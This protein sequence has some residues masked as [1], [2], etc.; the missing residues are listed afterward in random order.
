[1]VADARAS[2]SVKDSVAAPVLR[3]LPPGPDRGAIKLRLSLLPVLLVAS[4]IML[5]TVLAIAATY[6]QHAQ[7]E[8]ARIETI[9][10]LTAARIASWVENIDHESRFLSGS[11]LFADL[12]HRF[13]DAGDAASGAKMLRRIIEYRTAH[14][15]AST[16]VLDERGAVALSENTVTPEVAPMLRE[17]ALQ[18]MASNE[19]RHTDLYPSGDPGTPARIDFV[20]PLVFTGHPARAAIVLQVDPH[21]FLVPVLQ[22]W[23]APTRTG[24]SI[25]VRSEC[26]Q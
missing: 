6:R 4:A 2:P 3:A 19:I 5:A 23:P 22:E 1:M 17:T 26:G 15:A 8:G 21:E 7:E 24:T 11:E 9:A 20:A 16:L 25:L 14:D 13:N 12:Y 18:A 10:N